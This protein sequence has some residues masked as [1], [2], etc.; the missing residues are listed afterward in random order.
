MKKKPED[1]FKFAQ[2]DEVWLNNTT[3]IILMRPNDDIYLKLAAKIGKVLE[4]IF[5][6][7]EDGKEVVPWIENDEKYD[8]VM[9]TIKSVLMYAIR[10][11]D[12]YRL[13]LLVDSTPDEDGRIQPL[14][15]GQEYYED[16]NPQLDIKKIEE[17]G[18]YTGL[19]TVDKKKILTPKLVMFFAVLR[20]SGWMG[21]PEDVEAVESF[22]EEPEGNSETVD[23]GIIR[24]DA[25]GDS[26]PTI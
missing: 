2:M 9:D 17:Q 3:K 24:E 11:P 16:F 19:T 10:S 7:P 4:I 23:S 18:F 15:D 14:I 25:L 5:A 1:A 26:G 21:T 8:F 20:N 6:K 22:H 13:K 12:D